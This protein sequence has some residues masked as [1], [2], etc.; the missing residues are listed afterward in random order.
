MKPSLAFPFLPFVCA[1]VLFALSVLSVSA[2]RGN[3]PPA[4][5]PEHLRVVAGWLTPQPGSFGRP[6]SDRAAWE[7]IAKRPTFQ[8]VIPT[9]ERFLTQAVP[10]LPDDLYL[11]FSRTGNRTRWQKVNSRRQ[12]FL[13][14][15]VL[16]ECLENRGRFLPKIEEVLR[17]FCAER[18]WVMPAHDRG[19][20]N[21][22]GKTIDID[23]KSSARGWELATV[24]YLLGTKLHPAVRD[25][26]RTEVTRRILDPY[27]GMVSGKRKTNWWMHTT[28]NWNAVCL[29]GVTGAGLALLP[30]CRRRAL[31]VGAAEHYSQNFLRG[32][33]RDG[34]CSEG[35]GYWNYGFGH[36]LMLSELL[37]QATKG[38][39]D[40]MARPEV[41]APAQYG[42]RLDILNGVYPAFADCPVT[43]KPGARE[44]WY[45][46]RKY[47]LG[48]RDADA[49]DPASPGGGLVAALMY[50]FPNSASQMPPADEAA[51]GP[52]LRD[53][54]E[55]AGVLVARPAAGSPC[56]LGVALKGGHNA[57]HHNHNDV[58]SY[59]VVVGS[60][61]VLLD[62]GAETYSARTFSSHRY[63]SK[64]LNSFGHPVPR[65]AGKL[66]RPGA[67]ARA[68][69][70]RTEFTPQQ[71]TLVL[72]LKAA[73]P[74]DALTRLERTF[75]YS[76]RGT[77][78]LTIRD[79]VEFS[80]PRAFG[81]ALITRGQWRQEKPGT[82]VVTDFEEG[83]HVTIQAAGAPVEVVAERIEENAPVKP[84]RVGIDF[85]H[86]VKSGSISLTV[87]PLDLGDGAALRNG[88]FEQGL[89]GWRI[90]ADGFGAVS[91]EQAAQG[92][93]SL[94]LVDGTSFRGSNITA[95]RVAATGGGRFVL[96]GKYFGVSGHGVGLYVRYL[97]VHGRRLNAG[98][99]GWMTAVGTLGGR[100]R[101]WKP[102]SFAFTAP[103]ETRW[104]QVWI[105][106]GNAS[107]V[108]GYLDCLELVP[109][110]GSAGARNLHLQH[111]VGV[112]PGRG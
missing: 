44:R 25:L 78:S 6:L 62:P 66:Q 57:E 10:D 15:L 52:G 79:E 45:V 11:D 5:S 83:V 12:A 110:S 22:H 90:P 65:V 96:R 26:V 109:E 49:L 64:L 46:S 36:Y 13:S 72:D 73:Y 82:L 112:A 74:V 47:R 42:F 34:Y 4:L 37:F 100:D 107:R 29:A 91:T 50:S 2:A 80:A 101:R 95:A 104:L 27:E 75:I 102:F 7:G 43:A 1:A 41:K 38:R 20:A 33:T 98:A 18:T 17:A 14:P 59:V 30:S 24:L 48:H 97:D 84:T 93:H 28:N 76:R 81:T 31:Y 32:F 54:F 70:L 71:D 86:P 39:C 3:Q 106:T 63:D 67:K 89:W 8:D 55:D 69:V 9:A 40:L 56:R 16:A 19:L 88:G 92:A 58:G 85:V 61:P 99:R 111:A 68:T 103:K 105:H 94:K 35:V 23:L 60:T 87:T 51:P 77:G 108:E 53:W 21:F